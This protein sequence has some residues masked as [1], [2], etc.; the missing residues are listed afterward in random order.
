[1]NYMETERPDIAATHD[2]NNP[3][4]GKVMRAIGMKCRYSCGELWQPKNIPIAFRMHQLNFD[5]REEGI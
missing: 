4:S 5:G 1:M 3:E 2:I